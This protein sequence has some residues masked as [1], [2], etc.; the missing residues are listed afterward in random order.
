MCHTTGSGQLWPASP[1]G[2]PWRAARRALSVALVLLAWGSTPVA[3]EQPGRYQLSVRAMQPAE[4]PADTSREWLQFLG[5]GLTSGTLG[6]AA[7]PMY[8]SA[9]VVGGLLL[10]PTALLMSSRERRTWENVTTAL[11]SVAFEQNLLRALIERAQGRLPE[12][13]G[14]DVRVELIVQ[15]Y[16]LV[17]ARPERVCFIASA[18]LVVR[19]VEGE[20][21]R[22]RLSIT[23]TDASADAPPPQCASLE[24]FA[25]REGQLVRDTAA[26]YAQVL[27]VMAIDRLR[28]GGP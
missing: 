15:A 13:A 11:G 25:A 1:A 24:R 3:A 28:A 18:D 2:S 9:L 21:R 22:E 10:A 16:G 17:G 7:P 20:R 12:R 26:E 5:P 19:G 4:R 23:P 27:A 8:A 14:G 6:L